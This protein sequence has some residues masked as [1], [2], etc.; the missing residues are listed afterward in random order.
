MLLN[1]LSTSPS[2]HT[3][4]TVFLYYSADLGEE[5]AC[6]A[7][8]DF[9]AAATNMTQFNIRRHKGRKITIAVRVAGEDGEPGEVIV[10][11]KETSQEFKA[12]TKDF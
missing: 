7:L 6:V 9:L 4:E 1:A 11:D 10:T 5:E 12:E 8:A 3:I 2:V